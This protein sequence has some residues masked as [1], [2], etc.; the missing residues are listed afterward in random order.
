[1]Y[2]G[3]DGPKVSR[4]LHSF[5]TVSLSTRGGQMEASPDL[6]PATEAIRF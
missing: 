2:V 3:L 5:K 1:M 4:S 6:S